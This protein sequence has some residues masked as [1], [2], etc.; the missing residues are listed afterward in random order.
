MTPLALLPVL[1]LAP[2]LQP[3]LR[4]RP[5]P[6]GP[7]MLPQYWSI[8]PYAANSDNFFVLDDEDAAGRAVDLVVRASHLP[9]A[10]LPPSAREV[11]APGTR[12]ML[13]MRLLVVDP[14][15]EGALP[16]AARRTLRYEP[17]GDPP[18]KHAAAIGSR[19]WE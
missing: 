10:P 6:K 4:L 17:H 8:A 3:L 1:P 5:D 15:A 18:G 9:P 2:A 7:N 16:D 13:R 19:P 11:T 14:V 12:G